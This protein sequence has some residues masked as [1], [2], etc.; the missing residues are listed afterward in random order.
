LSFNGIE[1]LK[2]CSGKDR[3]LY[4]VLVILPDMIRRY[5]VYLGLGS[6]L[7]DRLGYL[8][9]AL[10]LLFQRVGSVVLVSSVYETPSMGFEGPSFLN[11]C[12][13][14]TTVLEPVQLLSEVKEVESFL[15]RK[16][17]STV[18]Y[19]SREIDI[20]LLFIDDEVI[21][22]EILEVP[23]S[24]ITE[25]L[26]V[27]QPLSEIAGELL[28]PIYHRSITSLLLSCGDAS[29]IKKTKYELVIPVKSYTFSQMNYLAI[30]GN[31]GSGK[32]T[33]ASLIADEFNGRL[34]LERFADNPFLPKFY[35]DPER[36]AFTLEMSFLADRY[37]QIAD[38]LS[39]LDLF[40]DFVVSDYY[41][42]KSLIFSKIT[43]PDD[44]F[45]LYR[46]LFFQM[47]KDL[48]QPDLYVYL[49]QSMDQLRTN[50]RKRGR[51]YEQ[52]ISEDYLLQIQTGYLNFLKSQ[53]HLKVE[54]IDISRKDFVHNRQ[55]FVWILNEIENAHT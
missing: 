7:G 50:I 37:R 34:M 48:P 55:D 22:D 30:E 24:K 5:E 21:K 38:D 11:A 4:F 12:C 43:L 8:Q 13:K 16:S 26:F 1:A 35:K 42:Y 54:I 10:D 47:Y 49:H 46:T 2:N 28:H 45:K 31:I 32:T 9:E 36:Y 40:K 18:G 20:D 25:R 51:A 3:A 53:P 15:G 14:I 17:P 29:E 41:V 27:L 33:L 6:N 44:E 23:H 52:N 19:S 39:Q